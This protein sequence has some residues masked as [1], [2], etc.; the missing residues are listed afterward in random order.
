[1]IAKWWS[2][3]QNLQID[4]Q[5]SR[6][7]RGRSPPF[8]TPDKGKN[9][10]EDGCGGLAHRVETQSD[11]GQGEVGNGNVKPSADSIGHHCSQS[12][13]IVSLMPQTDPI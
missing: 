2:A 11:E 7:M 4:P 3:R 12:H 5:L 10:Q 9:Q 6:L 8:N 1:M 13:T